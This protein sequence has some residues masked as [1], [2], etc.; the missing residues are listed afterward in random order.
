MTLTIPVGEIV[1]QSDDPLLQKHHTWE[2][3]L[4]GDIADVLNGYAFK[5]EF[6]SKSEGFPL[7][8]IRD[9]GKNST[10][11]KYTGPYD[12]RYLVNPGDLVIGMDGDFNSARWNGPQAL[13]N[14][15]V[16]R[17]DLKTSH[18][19][20]AFLYH[21][22]PGYLNAINANTSSVTVKHLSSRSVAE[23]PLPVPPLSEQHRIVAEIE[24]QFTRLDAGIAALRRAQANLRR[25]KASVLKA[26][27]EGRLVPTEA[28][29]ARVGAD[30]VRPDYEP[31][32]ALLQRILAER[33]AKWEA[34]NPGKK[35]KEPAAPDTDNL[36]DL[37]E[38]WVWATLP[39]LGE[40]NRGKSK[41]RPRN[42]PRLYGGPY[43]FIQ[44][45]DVKQAQGIIR[46]YSQAYNENGL[47]QSHLWP[48]GTLCITIAANIA[49]SAILGFEA[50]FPDSIVG[51]LTD[52]SHCDVHFIEFFIR[53]AKEDLKRYAPAT[54]Q[55]NINLR[56]LSQLGIV[57]PPLA[58]QHRI[59][60]EVERQLSV[61][62]ELEATVEANLK[63]AERLRQ[64]ILKQAFEGKLVPQDPNDEPA[65]ALLER[66][67]TAREGRI[68]LASR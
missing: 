4:L 5:S 33:R 6:F 61:V 65:S 23:I 68:P 17:V 2:R 21:A 19:D 8:R 45:G 35:Y 30:G 24:T 46:T 40:L 38:G 62:Q 39:Q 22:L 55:K 52:A 51:F 37:P 28:Q 47:A 18:Y 13:L 16:C 63:R 53:T 15:R 54:A 20:A 67:R 12:D 41:H 36:P 10:E 56:T 49:E 14:Q 32:D 31:A 48:I 60:A 27:C 34:E 3:V 26:A 1:N 43:P 44:T 9:V 57:L 7:L 66:I 59:V 58:E 50:C 64:A 29:L 25:Y 11:A 42:D